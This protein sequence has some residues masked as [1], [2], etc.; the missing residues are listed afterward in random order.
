[1]EEEESFLRTLEKGLGRMDTLMEK[2]RDSR[3]FNGGDAFELYDTFGFPI[4]LTRLIAAENDFTVD[5]AGFEAALKQ[6][7]ERSRAAT[8][9]EAEDWVLVGTEQ[10]TR[11][12]GYDDLNVGT[13]M[14]KYRKVAQKKQVLYQLVLESTPFYPESGGQVGDRGRL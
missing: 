10:P 11:F 5:E 1:R 4:D 6:Q 2:H 12:L 14:V 9:I 7:Q 8:A 13:R 3:V